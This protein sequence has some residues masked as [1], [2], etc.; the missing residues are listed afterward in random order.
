[1]GSRR[2]EL[3]NLV[4]RT[5]RAA[6]KDHGPIESYNASSA[7]KRIAGHLVDSQWD[8]LA[9]AAAVERL[10]KRIA[11]MKHGH[12]RTL[13]ENRRLKERLAA[14]EPYLIDLD[15]WPRETVVAVGR[16]ASPSASH[17]DALG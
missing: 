12:A 6:I 15:V 10:H 16:D 17:Q 1:M 11:E 8:T 4:E 9:G 13:D 7:A 5:L 2:K 14:L 3:H